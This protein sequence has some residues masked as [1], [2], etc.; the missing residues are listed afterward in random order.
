MNTPTRREMWMIIALAS[1]VLLITMGIR[2][3]VGLFVHPIV[4]ET[5]MSILEVSTAMAV[6]Q[7]AWGALQPVFGAWADKGYPLAA[8]A[9]GALCL[10]AGQLLTV[11]ADSPLLMVLA[12]G[13][14]SPA[15]AAAGA[16]S[17]LIG[18]VSA[19]ITP[20]LR[21]VAGGVINAGGSLGQFV[22][23][24]LI[25]FAMHLGGYCAGLVTSGLSALLALIP[26]S[27]LCREKKAEKARRQVS[28]QSPLQDSG[29]ARAGLGAQLGVAFRNPSYLLLHCGFFTCGFH[30]AFLTTHLPGEIGLHGQPAAVSAACLALIGLSNIVGSLGVGVAGKH[31][32]MKHILACMYASRAAMIAVYLAAPKTKT[33]FYIFAVVTGLTWL[34]TVPPTAGIVGKLFGVRYLATLFGL[35]LLT[36]QV[37]A[38]L[39]AWFGGLAMQQ[40]GNL[41]WV[42]HID[43]A[44]AAFAALVNL[45]IREDAPR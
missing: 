27:L 16:F 44:L 12:Q 4:A 19:R 28:A 23:A 18:I 37:G 26:A 1:A 41:L 45:P 38:F 11:W 10:A 34:A 13:L 32:R 17:V 35:T 7:L 15:G 36:H 21:S 40:S 8:L 31:F 30:V 22:F 39:G 9:T 43:I 25:Q 6:G 14:L 29:L 42:W 33:N 3:S 20:D 24:P 5:G 2:Q